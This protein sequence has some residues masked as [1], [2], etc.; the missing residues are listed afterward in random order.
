[1]TNQGL[2]QRIHDHCQTLGFARWGIAPAQ[3]IPHRDEFLKWLHDGKHGEM[4]WIADHVEKRLDPRKMLTDCQSI[5]VVADRYRSGTSPEETYSTPTGRIARYAQGV[6]YHREIK[7]RLFRLCDDL[8]A[9]FPNHTF[10]AAVDTAPV[11]END[12]AVRAGIGY[13]GKN[14][15]I[16]EPAIGSGLL[17]GEVLT[18]LPLEPNNQTITD[19]CGTC[20]RCIEA[21]PTSA[22]T[23]YSVDANRCISYLTI[24]H[25]SLIDP[26]LH[27]MMG[28]WIFG[29]DI[30]QEVCPHNGDSRQSIQADVNDAYAPLRSGFDLLEVLGWAEENRRAVLAGSAMK[31]AKRDMLKRNALIAVG[32]MLHTLSPEIKRE[33]ITKI[34]TM[35][36]PESEESEIVRGTARVLLKR[37]PTS[38]ARK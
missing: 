7:K 12:H 21:C 24:E 4:A 28:D 2:T 35:A 8:S 22:L 18:T 23:P 36:Q 5:I 32:G 6:D 30:C 16:I 11:K 10:R 27:E 34:K 3:P 15:L 33:F 19:H 37:L 31:R 9:Q 20:V 25:R 38:R 14:T 17:L 29:C 1:M 13:I 26:K